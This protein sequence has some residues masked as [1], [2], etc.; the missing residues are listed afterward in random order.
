M[1]I[2]RPTPNTLIAQDTVTRPRAVGV[3]LAGVGVALFYIGATGGYS[4]PWVGMIAGVMLA[5]LGLALGRAISS[6]S[7]TFDRTTGLVQVRTQH[8]LGVSATWHR[9]ADVADVVLDRRPGGDGRGVYRTALVMRDGTHRGWGRRTPNHLGADHVSAVRAIREFLGTTSSLTAP[10]GTIAIPR[11]SN[12]A[13]WAELPPPERRVATA[14]L[15][16]A[17]VLSS[18]LCG[19]GVWLV[20]TQHRLLTKYLSATATVEST[21]VV[22]TRGERGLVVARPAVRY[23]YRVDG[24]A[25]SSDGVTPFSESRSGDWARVVVTRYRSGQ[26]VTA[27]YDPANPTHAYLERSWSVLPW[28]FAAGPFFF[29]VVF[30]LAARGVLQRGSGA[31]TPDAVPVNAVA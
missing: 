15:V 25:Y 2:R 23:T 24:R 5:A 3:G 16:F 26:V 13:G 7:A 17:L 28:L 22:F 30:G 19:A 6:Q 14:M 4:H 12:P 8:I 27:Y 9:L 21:D 31:A 18:V 11:P 1:N 20:W 29:L 10:D